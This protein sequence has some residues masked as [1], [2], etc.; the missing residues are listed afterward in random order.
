[1]LGQPKPKDSKCFNA[2]VSAHLF[3]DEHGKEAIEILDFVQD[4][5]ESTDIFCDK[6]D[7]LL[8]S[9]SLG[10]YE[11]RFFMAHIRAWFHTYYDYYD[12]PQGEVESVVTELKTM[13]AFANLK[14]HH[15]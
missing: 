7:M 11:E 4:D 5:D 14:L 15:K 2:I 8:T 6:E 13:D 12:G 10:E 3:I 1:M 9:I